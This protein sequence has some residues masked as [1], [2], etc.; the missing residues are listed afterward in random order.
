MPEKRE[1]LTIG[2]RGSKLALWQSAYIKSLVEELTGA[3][4]AL[5]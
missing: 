5:K 1:K 4:V 3:E 2:T